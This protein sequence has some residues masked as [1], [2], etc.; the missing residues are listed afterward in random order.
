MLERAG[1]GSSKK[2]TN[3]FY[4]SDMSV[5][6]VMFTAIVTA[7][8]LVLGATTFGLLDFDRL[9]INPTYLGSGIQTS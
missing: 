6:K 1:F 8:V 3:Q 2:L 5:L 7:M 4:L 9:G